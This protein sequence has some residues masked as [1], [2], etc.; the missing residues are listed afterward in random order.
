MYSNDCLPPSIP[1]MKILWPV[2]LIAS[3]PSDAAPSQAHQIASSWLFAVRI[4][5]TTW[6]GV[7]LPPSAKAICDTIL[8]PG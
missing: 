2:A 3:V 1:V 6:R 5:S 7:V 8:M 4:L